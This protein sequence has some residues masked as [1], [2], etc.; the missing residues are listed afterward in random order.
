MTKKNI[1]KH[2]KKDVKEAKEGIRRDKILM[3]EYE[4][5]SLKKK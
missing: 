4:N 2:L 5:K 3:K 1:V